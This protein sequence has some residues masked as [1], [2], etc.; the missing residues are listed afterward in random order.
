MLEICGNIAETFG[1]LA[2]IL[3]FEYIDESD[4]EDN[5]AECKDVLTDSPMNF[6]LDSLNA[7]IHMVVSEVGLEFDRENYEVDLLMRYGVE[8]M[9]IEV[10]HP[11]VS[12]IGNFAVKA[13]NVV[14]EMVWF[15]FNF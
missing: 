10:D 6:R 4:E 1:Q 11:I 2:H 5:E 8:R 9:S 3:K 14:C 15:L 7:R 13:F 12:A